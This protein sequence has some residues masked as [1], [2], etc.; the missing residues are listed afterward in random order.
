[1][2]PIEKYLDEVKE[3]A[4]FKTDKELAERLGVKPSAI[5]QI[6]SGNNTPSEEHCKKLAALA[7]DPYEK[8]LLLAQVSKAHEGSRLAWERILKYA[9][10]GGLALAV[11][12][13]LAG[14]LPLL[15]GTVA[16]NGYYVKFLILIPVLSYSLIKTPFP[17]RFSV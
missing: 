13:V 1:M 15:I 3:K 11:T 17:P 8:V 16:H 7:G 6:K 9:A 12:L 14:A 4:G 5:C 10:K 2:R